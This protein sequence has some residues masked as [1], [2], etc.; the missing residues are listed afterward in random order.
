MLLVCFSMMLE[1]AKTRGRLRRLVPNRERE[2]RKMKE[3]LY[4]NWLNFCL[5]LHGANSRSSSGFRRMEHFE[6]MKKQISLDTEGCW[7]IIKV[8]S[9]IINNKQKL[10]REKASKG[11][12]R[13]TVCCCSSLAEML[14][15]LTMKKS[16]KFASKKENPNCEKT[17][18]AE[19]FEVGCF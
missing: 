3:K 13:G 5:M 7:A 12:R 15:W 10:Q 2:R 1:M 11:I 16:G 9:R 19:R 8:M 17:V 6:V 4:R 14:V 18:S